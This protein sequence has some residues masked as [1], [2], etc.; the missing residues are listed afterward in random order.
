MWEEED[1]KLIRTFEFKDFTEAFG[2][3]ARVALAAEKNGSPPLLVKC[4]EYS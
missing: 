4:L 2:F 3:M 1:N